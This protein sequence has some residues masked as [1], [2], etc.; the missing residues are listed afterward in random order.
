MKGAFNDLQDATLPKNISLL[1]C[2]N[3]QVVFHS[4]ADMTG[5]KGEETSLN[6]RVKRRGWEERIRGRRIDDASSHMANAK[7]HADLRLFPAS[8]PSTCLPPFLES[9]VSWG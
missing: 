8:F 9:P 4:Q 6:W 1:V 5:A 3:P 7:K 2:V